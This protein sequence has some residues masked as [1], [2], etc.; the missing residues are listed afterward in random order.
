MPD[1]S[2]LPIALLIIIAGIFILLYLREL[3]LRHRVLSNYQKLINESKIAGEEIVSSAI[4]KSQEIVADAE[5]QG[6]GLRE[7]S[8]NEILGG[9]TGYYNKINL[10]LQQFN[11]SIANE[12]N[13][14]REQL[15]KTENL[16]GVFIGELNT[17]LQDFQKRIDQGLLESSQN[18]SKGLE[19]QLAK[20]LEDL[21]QKSL[22]SVETDLSLSRKEIKKYQEEQIKKVN[23]NL[24]IIL[25]KT[26][27]TILKKELS[28]EDHTDLIYESF[29]YALKEGFL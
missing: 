8:E 12:L 2:S 26:L 20:F 13:N 15:N 16:N 5:H 18:A 11:D 23:E 29:N 17:R 28:L 1:L 6:L 24:T 4:K 10:S 9:Q 14:F 3:I 21:E 19:V 22:T 25:E 7:K 27:T